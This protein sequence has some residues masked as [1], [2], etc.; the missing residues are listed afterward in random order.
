MF[1]CYCGGGPGHLNVP[2]CATAWSPHS[3][4][5]AQQHSVQVP[6]LLEQYRGGD[7]SS[8]SSDG[9]DSGDYDPGLSD[10]EVYLE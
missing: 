2:T 7:A 5:P 4:S 1:M 9:E 10:S 8:S 6:P 3:S